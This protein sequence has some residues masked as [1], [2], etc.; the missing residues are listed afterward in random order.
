MNIASA[1]ARFGSRYTSTTSIS[2]RL[3]KCFRQSAVR[4]ARA[5]TEFDPSPATYSLNLNAARRL[6]VDSLL[7][8]EPVHR[9]HASRAFA[10]VLAITRVRGSSLLAPSRPSRV[11]SQ[12]AR[13]AVTSR[14]PR[15]RPL[16]RRVERV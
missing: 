3:G 9:H 8:P 13:L 5:S 11:V 6:M 4:L 16:P 10:Y 2:W 1:S 12:V 7:A 14:A 15:A